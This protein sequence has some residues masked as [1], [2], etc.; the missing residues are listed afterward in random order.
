MFIKTRLLIT[1]EELSVEG[2][3]RRGGEQH[4]LDYR[5][6]LKW[7]KRAFQSATDT[8]FTNNS[9]HKSPSCADPGVGVH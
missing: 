8:V 5:M 2:P 6:N 7:T 4:S 3:A 9:H 1:E